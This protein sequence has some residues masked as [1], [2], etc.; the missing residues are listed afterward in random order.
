M[1]HFK[2]HLVLNIRKRARKHLPKRVQQPLVIPQQKD[3]VWSI[4]FIHD[5]LYDRR[6]YRVLNVA[7]DF[8]RELRPLKMNY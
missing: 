6:R 8:N 5:S 4:D 2:I 7:D 3:Q 1:C